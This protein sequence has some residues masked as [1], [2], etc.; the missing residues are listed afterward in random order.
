MPNLSL[1][2]PQSP[3]EHAE[4]ARIFIRSGIPASY[5]RERAETDPQRAALFNGVADAIDALTAPAA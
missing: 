5:L 1:V 2:P 4:A 3:L